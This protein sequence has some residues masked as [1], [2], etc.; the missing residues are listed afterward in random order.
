MVL[1]A[2]YD[3]VLLVDRR[4]V[5]ELRKAAS[6]S[7]ATFGGCYPQQSV[8]FLCHSVLPDHVAQIQV[9]GR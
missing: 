2:L 6:A 7:Y 8:Y 9:S 4:N 3:R 5:L 1:V